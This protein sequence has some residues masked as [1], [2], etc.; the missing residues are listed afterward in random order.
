MLNIERV[1]YILNELRQKKAVLVSDLAK[2]YNVSPSTIRRDFADLEKEGILR[3]TYGGAVLVD[4][5]G[6][7]IPYAVRTYENKSEKSIIGKLA[8]RL[9][10]DEMYIILD[11]TSTTA[12]MIK[13]LQKKNDLKVIT[14]SA[15]IS[16]DCLDTLPAARILCT[17]GWMNGFHRSFVGESARQRLADFSCDL[18]FFSGRSISLDAGVTDVNDDDVYIKQQMIK[19]SRKVVYLCDNTK[20]DRVSYRRVCGLDALDCLVTNVRPSDEWMQAL[21]KAK[22]KVIYPKDIETLPTTD[23]S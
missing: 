13:Y 15:Q 8:A 9:V 12:H 2:R 22:V 14:N 3:R 21:E 20:F 1:D 16:L 11:G 18:L 17:G 4:Q 7:E 5:Q 23:E 19:S 10:R 6:S